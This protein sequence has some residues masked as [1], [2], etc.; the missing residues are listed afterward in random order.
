MPSQ[1]K[2]PPQD[3]SEELTGSDARMQQQEAI[4][5]AQLHALLREIEVG[6]SGDA[7]AFC[8]P[9]TYGVDDVIRDEVEAIKSKRDR[10]VVILETTGGYIEV[11]QRIAETLRHHYN[12]VEFIVPNH[13]MSAGTVLVM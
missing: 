3:G 12:L 5:E 6:M 8:G 2:P 11:A 13:A 1:K 10:I 4:I 9:I 7:V